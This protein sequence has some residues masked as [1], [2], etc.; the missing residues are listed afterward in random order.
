M[1]TKNPPMPARCKYK[2]Q[3]LS[4]AVSATTCFELNLHQLA[5]GLSL[6]VFTDRYRY[7]HAKVRMDR[8][9]ESLR[10]EFISA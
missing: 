1:A 2:L 10:L 4:K 5:F 3:T 6:A 7:S 9:V 8:Q